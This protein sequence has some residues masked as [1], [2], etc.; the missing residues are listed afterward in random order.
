MES[1]DVTKAYADK[2]L[3]EDFQDIATFLIYHKYFF[4]YDNQT[5]P[6]LTVASEEDDYYYGRLQIL[7]GDDSYIREH[8][9]KFYIY[10]LHSEYAND[11]HF[12][13]LNL[14]ETKLMS[15]SQL[16]KYFYRKHGEPQAPTRLLYYI[17]L[18]LVAILSWYVFFK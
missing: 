16:K 1:L 2:S 11:L 13:P 15:R 8:N 18:T 17:I 7:V 3:V 6:K 10:D 12:N 4:V 9:R 5:C 14:E